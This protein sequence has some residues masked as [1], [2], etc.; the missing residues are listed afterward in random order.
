MIKWIGQ[1]IWDFVSRFRNDVYLENIADGTVDSDK[2]LGL[3]S[4]GKIVKEAVSMGA[5]DLTSGVTGTLPVGNGGTGATTL[6]DNSILTGTGTSAITAEAGLTYDAETLTIGDDDDGVVSIIRKPHSDGNGGHI[7]I[8]GGD[9][10]AGQT[11]KA[12]GSVSILGG[13][14][15]GTGDGGPVAIRTYPAGTSTGTSLNFLRHDWTFDNDGKST[16][17]GDIVLNNYADDASSAKLTFNKQR[18]SFLPADAVDNDEIGKISF[19]GTDDGTPSAQQY[20]EI[21]CKANETGDGAEEGRMLLQVA[22]HDGELQP[23][24]Q[25]ISG[26]AEDEVNVSIANGPTSMTTVRGQLEIGTGTPTAIT[27]GNQMPLGIPM[28][29]RRTITQAEMNNLHTTPITII[30]AQGANLVAIPIFST[31]FFDRN[32]TNTS[33]GNFVIGYNS[34]SF[35]YSM[36]FEKSLFRNVTTDLHGSFRPY[37]YTYGTSLTAGVN[38]PITASAGSAYTTNAFTSLDIYIHYY[39]INRS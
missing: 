28:I 33:T 11:D 8:N 20:G 19:Y 4:N 23:G 3:D 26:D 37:A 34:P 7:R 14:S 9:A 18:G 35:T 32:L 36:F 13:R 22:S 12:G 16:F 29:A 10:T 1:H 39:V 27:S 5:V 31:Y 17:P 6:T 24:L 38:Q 21:L 15:T 2:F 30:P 25:M